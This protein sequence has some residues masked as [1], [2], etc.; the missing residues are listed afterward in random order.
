MT[1][2]H[3]HP[4]IPASGAPQADASVRTGR[5]SDAPAVGLVQASV[6]RERYGGLLGEEVTAQFEG[7]R[8]A[9][10]WRRSLEDPPG[11]VHR[12][13]VACAGSQVVGFAAVGPAEPG[14]TGVPDGA[15]ELL[16]LA[17]HGDARGV[18]HGSRLLNAA[19]DTLRANDRTAL[20]AWLPAVDE[21][22]RAFGA[23]AGLRPDG[24]WRERVVGP[25]GQTLR[26]VRVQATL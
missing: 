21:R 26:E 17:V 2:R 6:W 5:V 18:G 20:L 7:P 25:Q 8:F 11:P 13:L 23:H 14:E 24:A 12:L 9:A 3:T 15:A 22:A 16:D 4:E 10:V 19:A 1:H